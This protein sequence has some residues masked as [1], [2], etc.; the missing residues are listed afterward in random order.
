MVI[1]SLPLFKNKYKTA[2]Q[3]VQFMIQDDKIQ[4]VLNK[5]HAMFDGAIGPNNRAEYMRAHNISEKDW[6]FSL[7][8]DDIIN[9]KIPRAFAV[10]PRDALPLI[11]RVHLNWSMIACTVM[12]DQSLDQQSWRLLSNNF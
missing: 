1:F 8:A 9:Q 6:S 3:A 12:V 4:S 7:S 10:C 2:N 5:I 11:S